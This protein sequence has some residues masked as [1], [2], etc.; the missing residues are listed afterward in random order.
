VHDLT[1][2]QMIAFNDTVPN[3]RGVRYE[4][5]VGWV[6]GGI[7]DVHALLAPGFTYLTRRTGENDGMVSAASQ[8]WG[9]VLGEINADHWAQIGWSR[10]LDAKSFYAEVARTLA[11]SGL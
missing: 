1:T 6:R 3:M 7:G 10:G 5:Y 9:R 2:T 4:S 11:Q 8:R